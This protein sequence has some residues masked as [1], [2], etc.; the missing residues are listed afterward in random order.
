[1]ALSSAEPDQRVE[2]FTA[3]LNGTSDLA[4]PFI[5]KKPHY[6]LIMSREEMTVVPRED[7]GFMGRTEGRWDGARLLGVAL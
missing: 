7:D 5:P 4:G 6:N 2:A 1:M 3:L